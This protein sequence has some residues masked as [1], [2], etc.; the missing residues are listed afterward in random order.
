MTELSSVKGGENQG[1]NY[2]GIQKEELRAGGKTQTRWGPAGLQ[3][4]LD[5]ST[6]GS[7]NWG[8]RT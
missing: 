1:E 5:S 3:L 4:I 7:P 8:G 2:A 6:S